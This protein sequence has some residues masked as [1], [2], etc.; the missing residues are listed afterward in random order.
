M[1]ILRRRPFSRA[2]MVHNLREVFVDGLSRQDA[3]MRFA[4]VLDL[5]KMR[6]RGI[7]E[8][9]LRLITR[10][11]VIYFRGA[12]HIS[13]AAVVIRSRPDGVDAII[14]LGEQMPGRADGLT[15]VV[16]RVPLLVEEGAEVEAAFGCRDGLEQAGGKG[17]E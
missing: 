11:V 3:E 5:D 17:S 10:I 6:C 2:G 12:G 15:A 9:L 13:E 16:E 1:P 4:I 14:L 7:G 8:Q